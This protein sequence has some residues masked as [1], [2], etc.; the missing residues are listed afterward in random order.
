MEDLS[1]M[2]NPETALTAGESM[3]AGNT[4]SPSVAKTA[5][6]APG[7][8]PVNVPSVKP[9]THDEPGMEVPPVHDYAK[10]VN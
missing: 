6:A 8:M 2:L 3:S 9:R 1:K 5:M 7:S 10:K 4:V